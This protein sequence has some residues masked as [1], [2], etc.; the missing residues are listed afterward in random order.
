MSRS[1]YLN[2]SGGW[3]LSVG[4]TAVVVDESAAKSLSTSTLKDNAYAFIFDQK[5]LM[6]GTSIG[7][8][9]IFRIKR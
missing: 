9:K 1:G 3:E 7:G 2:K 5:G 6:F 4:P 8:T